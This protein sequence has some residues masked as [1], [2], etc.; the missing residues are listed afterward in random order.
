MRRNV[1]CPTNT[2]SS[3]ELWLFPESAQRRLGLPK[4]NCHSCELALQECRPES[5]ANLCL[6]L[7][8][9]FRGGFEPRPLGYE[10]NH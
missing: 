8:V 5:I 2:F 6:T 1:S 4:N 9:R 10:C 3:P 7:G